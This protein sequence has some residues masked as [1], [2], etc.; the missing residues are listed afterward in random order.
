[1]ADP[2]NREHV[3]GEYGPWYAITSTGENQLARLSADRT[4]P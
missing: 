3:F 1:V 4:T 2:S